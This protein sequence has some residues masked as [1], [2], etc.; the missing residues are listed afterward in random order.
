MLVVKVV[1]TVDRWFNRFSPFNYFF[2]LKAHVLPD[3]GLFGREKKDE[4]KTESSDSLNLTSAQTGRTFLVFV[5]LFF[6]LT[7]LF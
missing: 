5:F 4:K 6:K 7:L 2:L 3:F 1:V